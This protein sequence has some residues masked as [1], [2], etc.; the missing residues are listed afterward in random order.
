MES[1]SWVTSTP[2]LV[3][4]GARSPPRAWEDWL[5]W[6]CGHP[7]DNYPMTKKLHNVLS[8]QCSLKTPS[9]HSP[10]LPIAVL[11]SSTARTIHCN[12]QFW[13]GFRRRSSAKKKVSPT[14][15]TPNIL[16]RLYFSFELTPWSQNPWMRSAANSKP[17]LNS[18]RLYFSLNHEVISATFASLNDEFQFAHSY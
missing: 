1:G 14:L 2:D 9:H 6:V 15:C 12:L 18:V 16:L 13:N 11:H 8:G 10:L 4:L 7:P 5:L 3:R 17:L